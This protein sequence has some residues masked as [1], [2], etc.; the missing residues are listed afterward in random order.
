MRW[1]RFDFCRDSDAELNDIDGA[2][3]L[4]AQRE[5]PESSPAAY[6]SFD[7]GRGKLLDNAPFPRD[8]S[9]KP[10]ALYPIRRWIPSE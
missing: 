2:P 3:S 6:E 5:R 4:L 1:P 7:Q 8:D 10:P 9:V